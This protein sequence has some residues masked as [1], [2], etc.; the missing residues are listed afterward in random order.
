MHGNNV[1]W[2]IFQRYQWVNFF[3]H[4]SPQLLINHLQQEPFQ[5]LL[6][7]HWCWI[8]P[9]F[10]FIYRPAFTRMLFSPKERIT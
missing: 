1:L 7:T 6:D 10:N 9:L 5:Y 8:Q 2:K 4:N 3:F